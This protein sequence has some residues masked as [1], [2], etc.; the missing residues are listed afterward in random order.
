MIK[1][2]MSQTKHAS[3]EANSPKTQQDYQEIYE[4]LQAQES[5]RLT[6]S[7]FLGG[8]TFAAFAAFESSPI[9]ISLTKLDS[10]SAFGLAAAISLGM[11]TLIFLAVAVS[12][13]Q[14][15]RHLSRIS[16]KTREELSG[17]SPTSKSNL[18]DSTEEIS[19]EDV[20][21]RQDFERIKL[22]WKIHEESEKAIN[23]GFALLILALI[24]VGLAVNYSVG[25]AVIISLLFVAYYFRTVRNM[26]TTW[27]KAKVSR[28]SKNGVSRSTNE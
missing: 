24:L 4:K 17:N 12:A 10:G 27:M 1:A 23:L 19:L 16:Q 11:S 15:I 5:N 9:K 8:L 18:E 20:K 28:K 25:A 7:S 13:Y 6:I 26:L 3:S 21:I 14:S 22:A 2:L